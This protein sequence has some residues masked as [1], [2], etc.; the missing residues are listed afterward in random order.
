MAKKRKTKQEKKIADLRRQLVSSGISSPAPLSSTYSLPAVRTVSSQVS[1]KSEVKG[2]DYIVSDLRKTAI[3][4]AIAI[5]VQIILH[6]VL[7]RG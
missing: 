5:T 2:Y 1:N 6:F 3:L 4:T 7:T